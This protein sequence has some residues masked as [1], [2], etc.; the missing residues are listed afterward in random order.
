MIAFLALVIFTLFGEN[1]IR[2]FTSNPETIKQGLAYLNIAR[3]SAFPL[4]DISSDIQY[5]P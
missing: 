3:W 5:I 1:L 4:G 2:L